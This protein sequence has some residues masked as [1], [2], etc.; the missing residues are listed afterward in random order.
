M[1]LR[2][3]SKYIAF[4]FL[5]LVFAF[6]VYCS[7]IFT[8]RTFVKGTEDGLRQHLVAL[9]YYGN[10]LRTLLSGSVIQWDF[11][12]GE[13]NDVFQT[14]SYYVIG[15]PFTLLAVLFPA[16]YMY[17]CYT[18][19]SLLKLYCAGLA[20]IFMCRRFKVESEIGTLVATLSY[21]FSAW[22]FIHST[23]HLYFI[24]PMIYMPLIVVGIDR[25]LQEKKPVLFTAA[26]AVAGVSNL[27]FFYMIA[28]LTAI[29][30]LALLIYDHGKDYAAIF[31]DLL[32]IAAYAVVG[33]LMAMVMILPVL[34]FFFTDSRAGFH[35]FK[36]FFPPE[37]Y[38]KL[39]IMFFA[40]E[41][42]GYASWMGLSAV[43]FMGAVSL[44]LAKGNRLLKILAVI[45]VVFFLF[46]FFGQMLN[47]FFYPSH[48]WCWAFILLCCYV[49]AKQWGILVHLDCRAWL[50]AG[51]LVT[52]YFILFHLVYPKD[53]HRI[54]TFVYCLF[55]F[56][57]WFFFWKTQNY[58]VR[59]AVLIFFALATIVLNA[60]YRFYSCGWLKTCYPPERL[61][62]LFDNE[63]IPI[64]EVDNSGFFRFSGDNL[65]FNANMLN[66]LS[67]PQYYWSMTNRSIAEYRRSLGRDDNLGYHRYCDYDSRSI[68]ESLACVKYYCTKDPAKVPYGFEPTSK[69]NLYK[70]NNALPFGYTYDSYITRA[71]F[72]KFPEIKKQQILLDSI[73]LE[74]DLDFPKKAGFRF[75]DRNIEYKIE[76]DDGI[77]V[78]KNRFVVNR[79][80]AGLKLKFHGEKDA[81]TYLYLKGIDFEGKSSYHRYQYSYY[82]V[83]VYVVK[84]DGKKREFEYC[85]PREAYY[86]DLHTFVLNLGYS[87][88]SP[89]EITL[90]FDKKGI[91]SFDEIAVV[92]QAF[93]GYQAQIENLKKNSWT[94]V[95]FGTNKVSGTVD[96]SA[97]KLLLISIPYGKGWSAYIDGRKTELLQGNIMNLA[98]PVEKGRHEIELIYETPLLKTGFCISITTILL[99]TVFILIKRR[100]E[101]RKAA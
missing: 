87:K 98:L 101:G 45:S 72:E 55:F 2:P 47:G 74:S 56:V 99:F 79:E 58:G 43:V 48:R 8:G 21:C 73:V 30:V 83:P 41:G 84:Q 46:P 39:P 5:F 80:N 14:L 44:F 66:G 96:F 10:F 37:V 91:Y 77:S 51:S 57:I 31:R 71:D 49:L 50:F 63:I 35:A 60:N 85:L 95:H 61:E 42:S 88:E 68:L 93:E 26:V 78:E 82:R 24:N 36:L 38:L 67:S 1:I 13:G 69:N 3:K 75:N 23:R 59:Q 81:E 94:D 40:P 90:I 70:N 12:I 97:D 29:Y 6:L 54:I 9:T 52:L 17:V 20:F 19:I 64:K 33:T 53:Y 27:Y 76:A 65:T 86:V 62:V 15:D 11:N 89:K 18:L 32:T 22:A 25:L 28:L 100:K 7:Y 92:C 16:K 4:T 34:Y